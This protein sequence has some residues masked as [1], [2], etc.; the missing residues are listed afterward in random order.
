[1]EVSDTMNFS[2]SPRRNEEHY[3]VGE[4]R[5]VFGEIAGAES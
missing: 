2:R 5:G 4:V 1:M 3:V